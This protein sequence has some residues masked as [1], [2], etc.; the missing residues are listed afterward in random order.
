MSYFI[1]DSLRRTFALELLDK[2]LKESNRFFTKC[3]TVLL[4]SSDSSWVREA[5]EGR[6]SSSVGYWEVWHNAVARAADTRLTFR[7]SSCPRSRALRVRCTQ[8]ECGIR[9]HADAQ[10]PRYTHGIFCSRLQA[11]LIMDAIRNIRPVFTK[12]QSQTWW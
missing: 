2:S 6:Q 3:I 10:Q 1:I 12:C 5:R 4:I 7:R 11:I 8:L 9:P